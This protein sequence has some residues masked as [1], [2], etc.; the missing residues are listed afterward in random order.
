[1]SARDTDSMIEAIIEA[2]VSRDDGWRDVVRDMVRAYPESSVH[3]LAFALT[4][5]ASAIESMYLPQ[6]PSYPA[7]QR[8]YR[9]AALLGADIYAA[10]MRRVWVDDLASL[11]AYWRDH[12]DYFLTL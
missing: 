12:D 2:L 4:A 11:E 9:L 5:A 10:R 1:M 7:A 8:A 6:S 3:E